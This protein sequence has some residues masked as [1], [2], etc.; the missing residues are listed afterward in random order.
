MNAD[1]PRS[2][3]VALAQIASTADP[4]ENLARTER[5]L[6]QAAADGARLVVLP[7]ATMVR[8]G[9]DPRP[10]AEGLDGP[11]ASRV[12]ELAE[13][14]GVVAV[15]GMFT[16][17]TPVGAGSEAATGRSRVRNTLLVTGPGAEASY[18][19]IHLFDAYTS[20][21]SHT[22][23]PGSE[24]VTVEVDG[25]TI[26]LATCYDI[27]FPELFAQLARRGAEVMVVPAHWGTARPEAAEAS[28]GEAPRTAAAKCEAWR[29]LARA[30]ALDTTSIVI[31]V[32]QASAPA[33]GVPERQGQHFGK[34]HS[35]VV[36]PLGD[37]LTE[38]G[39]GEEVRVV[40]L[41]LDAVAQARQ[42]LPV[43]ENRR[44]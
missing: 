34:G 2:L 16:P 28:G 37:V 19:K 11:W 43:L 20:R 40:D 17:G 14:L 27:R 21:E 3:R 5:A 18:D 42:T 26:G 24:L 33:A 32:D 12:R 38:L 7:E 13:E 39:E 4:A 31:A 36:G 41:N 23:E 35:L 10:H 6:R 29:L 9:H 44:V 30:R 15:V 22:V 8:F 25:V 1:A